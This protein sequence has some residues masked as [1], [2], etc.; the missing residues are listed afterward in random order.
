[1]MSGE[2]YDEKSSERFG[3]RLCE[4]LDERCISGWKSSWIIG[5]I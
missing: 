2:W 1:M 5:Q 3:E 4:M